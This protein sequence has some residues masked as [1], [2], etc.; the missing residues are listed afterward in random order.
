MFKWLAKIFN[1]AP[2]RV[3]YE[4]IQDRGNGYYQWGGELY[5]SDI[6]RSCIQPHVSAIG[7]LTPVHVKAEGDEADYFYI[8]KILTEPNPYMAGCMLQEKLAAQLTLNRNAF[9]YINRDHNGYPIELYPLPVMSAEAIYDRGYNLYLRFVL[10]NGRMVTYPYRDVIHLRRD[11]YEN[12]IFGTSAQEALTPLMEL[13]GTS[14]KGLMDAIKNGAIIRW[15]VK[16]N[17]TIRPEDLKKQAENFAEMYL[18]T[19]G[20]GTGVA[21]TDAKAEVQQIKPNDYVPNVLQTDRT[22]RR[23]YSFFGVN[24][25]IVQNSYTEDEWNAFYEA[26]IEPVAKQMSDEF[27]RK[28][29][30]PR[31]RQAGHRI[32]F[33]AN[34]LQYASMSTKLNLLQM[35][36][37]GAMTPNE[38][39]EVLNMAPI[40]GGDRPIRRLDTAVVGGG[41]EEE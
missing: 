30:S 16:W 21:A 27:T 9:A 2:S 1:R 11:Y 4:V 37:R 14:D 40:E 39:R 23:I 18:S 26:Q 7:K 34:S 5:K 13:V 35:V 19:E 22:E 25:N 10:R 20:N 6:L 33:G 29:F 28:L 41:G 31:E 36:D 12:D 24:Q 17:Q 32:T 3:R 8:R 38:W 15:L